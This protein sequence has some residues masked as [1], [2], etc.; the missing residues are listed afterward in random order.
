MDLSQLRTWLSGV[1]CPWERTTC[2]LQMDIEESESVTIKGCQLLQGA[3]TQRGSGNHSNPPFSWFCSAPRCQESPQ[4]SQVPSPQPCLACSDL[5]RARKQGSLV[6]SS[7]AFG[8]RDTG[9]RDGPRVPLGSVPP[10][11]PGTSLRASRCLW[12]DGKQVAPLSSR[13]TRRG[14]HAPRPSQMPSCLVT[15]WESAP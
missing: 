7:A 6:C 9:R 4:P 13:A 8:A 14:V 11:F 5:R 15:P 12:E 10:T 2:Q 1:P 3:V